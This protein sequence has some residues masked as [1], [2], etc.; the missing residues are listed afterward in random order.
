MRC[1]CLD[2]CRCKLR[3]ERRCK[4]G[5]LL[6]QAVPCGCDSHPDPGPRQLVSSRHIT[7]VRHVRLSC[8][9]SRTH[10]RRRCVGLPQVALLPSVDRSSLTIVAVEDPRDGRSGPLCTGEPR[11]IVPRSRDDWYTETARSR[12]SHNSGRSIT[13]AEPGATSCT[14]R[15]APSATCRAPG[16]PFACRLS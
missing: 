2:G 10:C 7:D 11:A 16:C 4:R 5:R 6:S 1:N 15:S 8:G 13:A 12:S 9:G 14:S 3:D